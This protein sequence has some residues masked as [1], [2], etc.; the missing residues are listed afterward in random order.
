[1]PD[2][3]Y[4]TIAVL[5]G[6]TFELAGPFGQGLVTAVDEFVLDTPAGPSP[7]IQ[8]LSFGGVPFYYIR[9]HGYSDTDR[10]DRLNGVNFVRMFA[11]LL[12]LEVR[13]AFGG[14]TS[15]GI[16]ETYTVGDF[17]IPHDLLD[18]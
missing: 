9:F 11:A 18:F 16:R 5:G 15:G 12:Q 3:I 1:M 13:Y 10:T 2:K 8:R 14:A 7:P 4:S 17:V 6:T